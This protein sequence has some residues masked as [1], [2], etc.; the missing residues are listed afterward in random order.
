VGEAITHAVWLKNRTP[1]R[2]LP[3]GKTPYEMLYSK[4]PN[5]SQLKE[6]GGI[7]WVH[8]SEGTKLDGRSKK[9][10]W[11]GFDE[12]SNG[13]QIYWPDKQ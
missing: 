6:W 11:I 4:K 3:D 10:K 2:D 1:T 8:T 13:H 12:V 7:V 9:G 5:L